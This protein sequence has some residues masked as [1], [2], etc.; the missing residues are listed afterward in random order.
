MLGTV[1][2]KRTK[3]HLVHDVLPAIMRAIDHGHS[4]GLELRA[5]GDRPGVLGLRGHV[6]VCF[7]CR[8]TSKDMCNSL[9]AI[10][11]SISLRTQWGSTI[12]WRRIDAMSH[13]KR[14]R[15]DLP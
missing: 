4:R 12:F 5:K 13:R 1:Y 10:N 15:T 9:D 2:G 7:E 11:N 8:Y 3:N 14:L 6:K